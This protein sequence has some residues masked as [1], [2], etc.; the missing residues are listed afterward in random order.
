M[1]Y[2]QESRIWESF[3]MALTFMGTLR[4]KLHDVR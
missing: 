1:A 4:E 3:E 2:T